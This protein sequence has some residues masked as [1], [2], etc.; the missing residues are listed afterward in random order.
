VTEPRSAL[1]ELTLARFRMFFREPSAVFWTFGFP[2]L[3]SIALGAAFRNRPP[4]AVRVAIE[5][6]PGADRILTALSAPL[7]GSA[8]DTRSP[9]SEV[10]ATIEDTP[11]AHRD[12]RTGKVVLVIVPGE[13]RAY[14]YDE[15]RPEARLARAMVD[16]RLQRAEGR[17]D[18]TRAVD[19]RVT[20]RGTRYI[21]FLIPGLIGL[22]LMSSS[23]W[24][25]GYLIVDMRTRKLIKRMLAT[26]MRRGDFLLSFVLMRALFVL[27]EVPILLA[28]GWI[29]FGVRVTGSP[30][31]ILA[32]SVLGALTF[33]GLGLLVASRAQ[34]TQTV[35][36]LM[37]LVMMPMFIGS[38]VFFSASK[39][40]DSVQPFVH[41]LPLT[42][43]NDSLR[44]VVNEGATLPEIGRP[45]AILALWGL[46]SF[47]AALRLFRWI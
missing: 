27:F 44:A 11:L 34:N 21:D 1:V 17:K 3:L 18:P 16:D 22:N 29:A 43:L 2:V 30:F 32:L 6:G 42:I 26:P 10:K 12:L 24:G 14:R 35:G 38:G 40:P 7:E 41:A 36:G 4:E 25:I 8:D 5:A 20:E 13:P 23:M 33:A 47:A 31:L 28:F 45:M 39:F 46:V 37:N 15:T 9:G 19:E